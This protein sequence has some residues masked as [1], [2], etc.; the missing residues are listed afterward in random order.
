MLISCNLYIKYIGI[1]LKKNK[2]KVTC[3][4]EFFFRFSHN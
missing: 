2:L 1:H 4:N 3:E